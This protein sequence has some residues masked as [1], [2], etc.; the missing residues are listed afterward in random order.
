MLH[1]LQFDFLPLDYFALDISFIWFP[2]VQAWTEVD[3]FPLDFVS[4]LDTL[5]IAILLMTF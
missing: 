1:T 4:G 3:G 5:W 2:F